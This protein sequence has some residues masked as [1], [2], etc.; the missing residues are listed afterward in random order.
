MST[1]GCVLT[2]TGYKSHIYPRQVHQPKIDVK[3]QIGRICLP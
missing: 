3:L 2:S 1:N